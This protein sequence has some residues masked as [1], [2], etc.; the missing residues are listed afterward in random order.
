MSA[1]SGVVS[2]TS[3]E[4]GAQFGEFLSSCGEVLAYEKI[5]AV[6]YYVKSDTLDGFGQVM[7]CLRGLDK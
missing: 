7:A 5:D 4:V 1:F 6:S 3:E 2:L